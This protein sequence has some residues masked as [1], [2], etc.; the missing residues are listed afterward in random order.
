MFLVMSMGLIGLT[1]S[2]LSALPSRGTTLPTAQ[3]V[4]GKRS[5]IQR[6]A[7]AHIVVAHVIGVVMIAALVGVA[8]MVAIG[9]PPWGTATPTASSP[10]P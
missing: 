3:I 7:R 9:H 6:A 10:A 2:M 1:L 8:C 5:P 4:G